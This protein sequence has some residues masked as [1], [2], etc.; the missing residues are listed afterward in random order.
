MIFGLVERMARFKGPLIEDRRDGAVSPR[1][2][3]FLMLSLFIS[4]E[5]FQFGENWWDA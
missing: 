3:Q 4:C 2:G 1:L 5:Y